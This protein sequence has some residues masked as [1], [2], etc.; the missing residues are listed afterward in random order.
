MFFGSIMSVLN[1]S[2]LAVSLLVLA[3]MVDA[4]VSIAASTRF[5]NDTGTSFVFLDLVSEEAYQ[6]LGNPIPYSTISDLEVVI[7]I[8]AI[9]NGVIDCQGI[10]PI[11]FTG[12]LD[13]IVV[14]ITMESFLGGL[15]SYYTCF[16]NTGFIAEV[17]KLIYILAAIS[18]GSLIFG[19][20]LSLS[21]QWVSNRMVK[22][23]R[24]DLYR[25]ILR[26]DQSWFDSMDNSAAVLSAK[27][28]K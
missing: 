27:L 22:R 11:A 28:T 25:A 5:V 15:F 26:Q 21:F 7:D 9:T 8:Q 1:G 14:N 17:N 3:M 19:S 24:L 10:I 16:D 20:L 12:L 4:F 6:L 18:G 13:G 23:L 2:V